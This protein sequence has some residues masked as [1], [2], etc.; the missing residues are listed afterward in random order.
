MKRRT[1]LKA[2]PFVSGAC[3]SPL[4]RL[5]QSQDQKTNI[6]LILA[7]DLGW[8]QLSCYGS[9]Y[10]ETPNLDRLASQGMQFTDAYAACPVCSP[11]RA[12]IVTGKYP[13]RL[14]LTDFIPGNPFP[15]AKL[16]Q[17]DW[18]KYLPLEE[19]TIA[20][21]LRSVG[22]ATASFGK[23]H[24]S[25]E[26]KPP[27]SLPFNPEEQ[28]F[29]ESIVTYKPTRTQD[30]EADAHNVEAITQKCLDFMEK[31]RE[32]PFFLYVPHNSIHDPLKEKAALVEKY[33]RKQGAD[34]PE[35]NPV[36]GAMLETLD[37]SVGRLMSKLTELELARKTLFI[38]YSDNGGLKKDAAQTPLRG[39]K[40]QLYEGGIRVP[41][42]IRW[43]GVIEAGSECDVP[44]SSVDMFPTLAEIGGISKIKS[45]LDGESLLTLLR[46]QGELS[47]DAIFWHYPHYHSAGIAP[48]SAIRKGK[49]KLIE[50]FDTSLPETDSEYE[51]YDLETDLGETT[52]LR[53]ELPK[54]FDELRTR[55]SQWRKDV[56]AQE[57]EPNPDYDTEKAG[58]SRIQ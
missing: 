16:R 19:T 30:P 27:E 55:L 48:S 5:E 52:N 39:G 36:I 4:E 10:Y 29:D 17:P 44:V 14:H 21:I 57:L 34:L 49:Y 46:N 26:K 28:G 6:V 45:D 12:S 43:P 25:I 20:E 24:L 15:G 41:L 18:R 42:I 3:S 47:R 58:D 51:L 54:V 11:T 31:N 56:G 50:W 9:S 40:A 8:S 1:F 37:S 13:A 33:E 53:N 2:L 7:D 38:F 32:R 35:N 22:Y 23:W